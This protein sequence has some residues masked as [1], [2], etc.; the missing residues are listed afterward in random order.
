MNGMLTPWLEARGLSN[1]TRGVLY[2]AVSRRGAPIQVGE[3]SLFNGPHASAVVSWLQGLEIDAS[4]VGEEAF[5][6]VEVEKLLWNCVFG[7][8]CGVSGKPVGLL[9]DEHIDVVE[10]MTKEFIEVARES[11]GIRLQLEQVLPAMVKYS[12]SISDY[13]GRVS[14]WPF[15]NG[16]FVQAGNTAGV[17]MPIHDA[18]VARLP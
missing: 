6:S 2:F 17:P 12:H 3:P 14:D 15:R 13:V 1:L 7:L 10:G 9:C 5:Q 18:W 4:E 16:W 11:R 8:L